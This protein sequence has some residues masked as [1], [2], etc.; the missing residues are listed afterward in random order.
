[1]PSA[2]SPSSG[3]KRRGTRVEGSRTPSAERSGLFVR[4]PTSSSSLARA[5]SV[6]LSRASSSTH[7][8]TTRSPSRTPWR[9]SGSRGT[10]RNGHTAP[11]TGGSHP[12]SRVT[13]N[14][15]KRAPAATAGTLPRASR[16]RTG[17]AATTASR[18]RR[19]PAP[20]PLG[21][22][23][24]AR[25]PRSGGAGSPTWTWTR[26]CRPRGPRQ[27][28][29]QTMTGPRGGAATRRRGGCSSPTSPATSR[30]PRWSACSRSTGGF[31]ASRSSSRATGGTS[32]TPSSASITRQRPMQRSRPCM[33]NTRFDR[34][35]V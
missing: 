28:R 19:P 2:T 35:K 18:R 5:L 29:A 22:S 31:W 34:A 25:A 7:W 17:G 1:M 14:P 12:Q 32:P 8:G 4:R 27:E 16:R 10:R 6:S 30:S 33:G 20:R 3:R 26:S 15:R 23:D 9:S 21:G 24:P 11:G 13:R